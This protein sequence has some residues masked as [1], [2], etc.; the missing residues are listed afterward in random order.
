MK[1]AEEVKRVMTVEEVS[2]RIRSGSR[3]LLA[4]DESLLRALPRGAWLGGTIPY[5]M[6]EEGGICTHDRLQVT[7]LPDYASS[8]RIRL[9]G[10]AELKNIPADYSANGFSIVVIPAFSPAHRR[11][12]QECSNWAGVFESPLVGWVAGIDLRD[13]GKSFPKVFNGETGE[14]SASDAAVM[15]IDLPADK[16]AKVNIVN[17]FRQGDG[18]T[19]SFSEGGFRVRECLVNGKRRSFAE[20]LAEKG[21]DTRWPL[22]ANYAGAMI[23][24]SFQ[25]VDAAS[26]EVLLYAPVFPAVNYKIAAPVENY[27]EQFRDS[28]GGMERIEPVFSC[29]CILNYLH[30]NLDGKKTGPMMGPFTFGEIAYMLLNQTLVYLTIETK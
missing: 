17:V 12:A 27:E 21:V 14:V 5:F 16:Y 26:G 23:N 1:S 10:E 20:Y 9:Y 24:V 28:L 25:N 30:A 3:M 13:L 4:G 15:H 18:D 8:V 22:V 19:I 2:E 29:N 6:S 11:F 7:E